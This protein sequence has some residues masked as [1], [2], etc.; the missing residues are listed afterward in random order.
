MTMKPY[1]RGVGLNEL[2]CYVLIQRHVDV[3]FHGIL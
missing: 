3:I 2:L 1:Y